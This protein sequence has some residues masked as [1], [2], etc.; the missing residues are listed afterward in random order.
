MTAAS[1]S[2]VG[3]RGYH[4]CGCDWVQ[5]VNEITP[6]EFMNVNGLHHYEQIYIDQA[7]AEGKW[8]AVTSHGLCAGIAYMGSRSDVLW[9]APIGE[10][11]KYI[12][13]RDA[14]QLTNYSRVGSA[15]TFD[16]VHDLPDFLRQRVDGTFML[17]IVFDNPVT[18]KVHVLDTDVVV[19]VSVDGIPVSFSVVDMDG[20][21]FVLFETSLKVPHSVTV[22]LGAP[23]PTIG[24]IVDNGPVEFGSAAEVTAVVTIAEAS[25]QSVTLRVLSTETADYP[26]TLVGGTADQYRASFLPGQLG[27]YNYDVPVPG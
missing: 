20:V 7:I 9:N 6:T 11:L 26:M 18:L 19:D 22:T 17:P 8:A 4:D 23:A 15:I 16:A 13:V 3:V 10:V 24:A 14:A 1:Y 12:K 2:L 5:D 27:Q 21:R 25:I